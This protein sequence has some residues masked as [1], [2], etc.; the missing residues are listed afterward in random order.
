VVASNEHRFLVAESLAEIGREADI[1]LEPMPKNSCPA[2]VAACCQAVTRDPEAVVIVLA[3]DHNV[4]DVNGFITSVEAAYPMCRDE[5]KLATFGIKPDHPAVGYGYILPEKSEENI[6]ARAVVRFVEKPDLETAKQYVADGY[7]WNSGNFMFRAQVF[8]DE[9]KQ[10]APDILA[11]VSEAFSKRN[12]DL[13]FIRLDEKTFEGSPSVSVDYAV[14]ERTDR[15]VVVAA[16]HDWSDIG[17]WQ[18]VWQHLQKAE[19]ENALVGDAEIVNGKGNLVHS[20]DRLTTLVDVDDLMVISTS[21]A[22][23]VGKRESSEKIKL[24]VEKLELKG[25]SEATS[26]RKIYRPWGA[27]DVIDVGE[28]YKV[29]RIEVKPNGVLSLQRHKHRAEHWVVVKGV[30][31]VRIGD[32]TKT[33]L[34]NQS[35]YIPTGEVHRL[36][37][38][39]DETAVLIEVQT[40]DY[41]GEDDIERLED[42]YNRK[43]HHPEN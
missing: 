16:R 4:D 43:A 5:A 38:P 27:F 34:P 15:A 32:E 14:M 6:D 20:V 8:L 3:A 23:L 25:R 2:I 9:V 33:L 11:S 41:L 26:S 19:G 39:A 22:L 36:S 24:L 35:V 17:T 29:K 21:D 31:E 40:G 12:R 10:Y 37:N 13:D 28:N 1:L 7:L 18:S 42:A 30:T